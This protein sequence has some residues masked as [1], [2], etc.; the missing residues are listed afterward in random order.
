MA[1]LGDKK[2]FADMLWL[3]F[4]SV[5]A[6]GRVDASNVAEART[7]SNFSLID[8]LCLHTPDDCQGEVGTKISRASSG[9]KFEVT[10]NGKKLRIP[11][12]YIDLEVMAGAAKNPKPDSKVF[13]RALLPGLAP[14]ISKNVEDFS[15]PNAYNVV[16]F[17]LSANG[18][19]RSGEM[20]WEEKMQLVVARN[21][22]MADRPVRRQDQYGLEIW[23]EDFERYPRRAPCKYPKEKGIACGDLTTKDSYHPIKPNGPASAM[24]CDPIMHVDMATKIMEL[25]K[26][27]RIL[28]QRK[29]DG[30][31][32]RPSYPQCVHDM[33]YEPLDAWV[34]VYYRAGLLSQWKSTEDGIRALL[35]SFMVK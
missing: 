3:I 32:D 35:D 8:W 23:G 30:D 1:P 25:G 7:E 20:Q 17:S 9:E 18:H 22:N 31:P 16:R 5:A 2:R 13:L 10:I 14:R 24:A 34:V 26:S 15:Y 29:I 11:V 28:F 21:R 6:C 4:L 12:N 33:L 27:E 19:Q